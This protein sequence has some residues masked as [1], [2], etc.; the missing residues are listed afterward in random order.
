[1]LEPNLSFQD[2]GLCTAPELVVVPRGH[3]L[4]TA[5]K[6]EGARMAETTI[7]TA[8][9]FFEIAELLVV[10]RYRAESFWCNEPDAR[11]LEVLAVNVRRLTAAITTTAASQPHEIAN[12]LSAFSAAVETFWSHYREEWSGASRHHKLEKGKHIEP[13][14][15]YDWENYM[16]RASPME[17]GHWEMIESAASSVLKALEPELRASFEVS[18]LLG[19]E[20]WPTFYNGQRTRDVELELAYLTIDF[21]SAARHAVLA[22]VDH[23]PFLRGIEV[24][25]KSVSVFRTI[26][27]ID[28]LWRRIG[29]LLSDPRGAPGY[30]GL[31]LNQSACQV[32]RLGKDQTLGGAMP[33]GVLRILEHSGSDFCSRD[34]LG[35]AWGNALYDAPDLGT[36]DKVLSDLRKVLTPLGIRIKNRRKLGWRLEEMVIGS[37]AIRND[38]E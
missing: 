31:V 1:M 36:L 28:A 19:G 30:L 16:Y 6:Y 22:L 4:V 38:A 3:D 11:G 18:K 8:S 7:S 25:F 21:A 17:D 15:S 13:E 35:R 37:T 10:L 29:N 26:Q 33:W 2:N 20:V 12:R 9:R 34:M 5:E 24:D 23:L 32:S 14:Q 27:R